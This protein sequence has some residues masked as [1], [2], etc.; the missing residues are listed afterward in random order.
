ME[1]QAREIKSRENPHAGG[2]IGDLALA[3]LVVSFITLTS[4]HYSLKAQP[5]FR[6][7]VQKQLSAFELRSQ[8]YLA[9]VN[10]CNITVAITCPWKAAIL[11]LKA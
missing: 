6:Q 3:Q 7:F 2:W 1:Q 4:N 9:A 10:S 5:K 11:V 8:P